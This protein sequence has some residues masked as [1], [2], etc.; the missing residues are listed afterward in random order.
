[1]STERGSFTT[2]LERGKDRANA[3]YQEVW[4]EIAER[5]GAIL[6]QLARQ[7]GLPSDAALD[8]SQEVLIKLVMV[9][10]Q[11]DRNKGRARAWVRAIAR[12]TLNDHFRQLKRTI[13]QVRLSEEDQTRVLDSLVAAEPHPEASAEK[14]QAAEE[15]L[16]HQHPPAFEVYDLSWKQ[17]M[18]GQA[19]AKQLQIKVGTV[20]NERSKALAFLKSLLL[21]EEGV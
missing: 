16:R 19:V 9:I 14:L 3:H 18:S 6:Y 8:L 10:G 5:V 1:M 15:Q 2:W 12:N 13:P 7:C 21:S 20:Y 17:G 11:F 4:N